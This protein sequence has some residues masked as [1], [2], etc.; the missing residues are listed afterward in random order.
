MKVYSVTP[1]VEIPSEAPCGPSGVEVGWQ[2]P[3][4]IPHSYHHGVREVRTGILTK[5]WVIRV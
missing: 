3:A 1:T 4:R 2:R 5:A